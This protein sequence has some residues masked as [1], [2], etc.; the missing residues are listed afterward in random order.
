MT[1]SPM[2]TGNRRPPPA[3]PSALLEKASQ[4][5]ARA[6]AAEARARTGE[7]KLRTRRAILAGTWLLQ[8]YGEDLSR[9]TPEIRADFATYLTRDHDRQAFGLPGTPA[10]G[11]EQVAQEVS[12]ENA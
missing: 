8:R 10:S 6:A 7:R 3:T 5:R 1:A 4:L 9:L 11:G 12:I 2:T